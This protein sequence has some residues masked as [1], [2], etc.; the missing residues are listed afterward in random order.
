M[1]RA[2]EVMGDDVVAVQ[3]HARGAAPV[4]LSPAVAAGTA[5]MRQAL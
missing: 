3:E 4:G 1:C 5:A 2:A